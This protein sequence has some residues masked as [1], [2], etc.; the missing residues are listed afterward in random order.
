VVGLGFDRSY[1]SFTR[2]VRAHG[3]RPRCEAC[4]GVKGRATIEID[5]PA[6]EEIQ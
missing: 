4:S 6:G 2:L 3:L 5:H 1:P